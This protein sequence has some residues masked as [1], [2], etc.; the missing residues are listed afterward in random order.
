MEGSDETISGIEKF[1]RIMKDC[2]DKSSWESKHA[3]R[4][5]YDL[6]ASKKLR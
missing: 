3:G 6:D 5:S 1:L 4:P 2:F